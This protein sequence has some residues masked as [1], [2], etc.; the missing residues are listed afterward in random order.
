MAQCY[1]DISAGTKVDESM[2]R[3]LRGEADRLGVSVA[4]VQ[5]RIFDE[6]RA[7]RDGAVECPHCGEAVVFDLER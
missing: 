4:E 5:R 7:T 6:Y 2:K 3:F 1:G